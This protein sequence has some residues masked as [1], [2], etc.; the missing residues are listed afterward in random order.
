MAE[1]FQTPMK[2]ARGL[3]AARHGTGHFIQQRVS[4]VALA[5]L[6]PWFAISAATSLHGGYAAAAGWLAAPANAILMLLFVSAAFYHMR[7]GLQVVI[8]DYIEVHSTRAALLIANTFVAAG[9]WVACVF[10]ILKVA[11]G[12]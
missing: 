12:G 4:A 11:F 6:L 7:L 5:A 10:S 2:R 3:G 9:L 1:N 8:E